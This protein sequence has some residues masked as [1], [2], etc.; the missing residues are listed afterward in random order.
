MFRNLVK[1]FSIIGARRG[2]VSIFSEEGSL[3]AACMFRIHIYR[4]TFH[5]SNYIYCLLYIHTYIHNWSL[6]PFGQDHSLASHTTHIVCDNFTCEWWDLQ[7]KV[8][9]D[10]QIFEKLFMAILFKHS[11]FLPEICWGKVTEEIF[12][13]YISMALRLLTWHTRY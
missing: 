8:D 6:Q 12:F 1:V 11:E 7:F 3:K 4:S 13:S 2:F 5:S 10:R 9:S